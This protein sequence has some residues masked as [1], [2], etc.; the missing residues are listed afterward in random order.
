[1]RRLLVIIALLLGVATSGSAQDTVGISTTT[2]PGSGCA[3]LLLGG[4]GAVGVQITGTFVGTIVFEQ[5]IDGQ[6][7][8]AWTVVPSVGGAGVTSATSTGQW[9]G[10]TFGDRQVRARFNPYSSGSA[11]V[12][13]ALS[14]GSSVNTFTTVQ[15]LSGG[16]LFND[17]STGAPSLAF[18]NETTNGF[19]RS[20]AG[21][22][23]TGSTTTQVCLPGLCA[24]ANN[25]LLN[26]ATLLTWNSRARI[27]SDVDGEVFVENQATTSG[28]RLKVDALPT[29]AS[30][31]GTTP[32]V[33]AGSTPFAG[34][35]NVGTGGVAT[36]GVIAFGGT[37]F[38]SV[39]FCIVSNGGSS[40]VL[41]AIATTTQ[42]TI[43]SG[44][45]FAASS[46]VDW[47]CVASK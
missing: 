31:F 46:L 42:L 30:G 39:P 12:S 44:S 10:S 43:N 8:S 11:N 22:I 38:P 27:G 1:M 40:A 5:T 4:Q 47:I 33:T 21:N 15:T 37:A 36:S 14:T 16:A 9:V 7:W 24:S 20:G 28:A 19:Y 18:A 35:V 32:G 2:C 17:G 6:T 45:A 41:S 23:A 3:P 26:A 34:S 29:V 25:A 13:F